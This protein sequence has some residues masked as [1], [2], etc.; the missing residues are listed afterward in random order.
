M[1]AENPEV[2]EKVEQKS[3]EKE[4]QELLTTREK[5]QN[6]MNHF[7]LNIAK[8]DFDLDKLY[9]NETDTEKKEQKKQIVDSIK[10]KIKVI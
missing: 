6:F 8:S 7:K 10:R 2:K 3:E 5:K 1:F 4:L 9:V